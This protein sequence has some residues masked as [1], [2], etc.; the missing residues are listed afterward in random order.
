MDSACASLIICRSPGF[1][2]NDLGVLHLS[3]NVWEIEI[4]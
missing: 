3:L 2:A 1:E 4:S